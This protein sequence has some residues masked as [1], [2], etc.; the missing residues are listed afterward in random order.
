[1]AKKQLFGIVI[2]CT[3]VTSGWAVTTSPSLIVTPAQPK[4]SELTVTQR[5]VLAPLSDDWD[6]FENFRQKKWL[7]IASRF[8]GMMLEE[9]RRIQKQMQEWGKLTPEERQMARENFKAAK[10]LPADK[11]QKL[12][13]KWQEYANLPPE[14]KERFKQQAASNPPSGPLSKSILP[15]ANPT[16]SLTTPAS[17]LPLVETATPAALPVPLPTPVTPSPKP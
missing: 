8:P 10:E 12:K 9:Q 15:A 2:C 6:S 3:L 11:K 14:E 1:M 16:G 13:Q 5:I 4:W 17:A 7:G